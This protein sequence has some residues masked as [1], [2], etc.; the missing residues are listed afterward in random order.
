MTINAPRKQGAGG[1]DA[2]CKRR[3]S[4]RNPAVSRSSSRRRTLKGENNA[5]ACHTERELAAALNDRRSLSSSARRSLVRCTRLF[6][7]F[8]SAVAVLSAAS[9]NHRVQYSIS[10]CDN[11]VIING[12]INNGQQAIRPWSAAATTAE[13]RRAAGI[14]CREWRRGF[15]CERRRRVAVRGHR[16]AKHSR[17]NPPR[18]KV[19]G[20]PSGAAAVLSYA[21]RSSRRR[22]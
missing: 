15:S 21:R 13:R 20:R 5:A 18:Q 2:F 14:R 4:E 6:L 1:G 7:A 9:L 19:A 17:V 8:A 12:I 10:R 16:P 11:V 22:H 3:A